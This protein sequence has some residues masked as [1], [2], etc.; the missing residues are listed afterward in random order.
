MN[1]TSG[2]SKMKVYPIL[3]NIILVYLATASM[4]LSCIHAQTIQNITLKDDLSPI[5]VQLSDINQSKNIFNNLVKNNP[6]RNINSI[7][8]KGSI[9][10]SKS[11]DTATINALA[12]AAVIAPTVLGCATIT[13]G[14]VYN[15]TTPSAGSYKCY[16]FIINSQSKIDSLA[17]LP[18]GINGS[19]YLYYVDPSTGQLTTLL[20][21]DKSPSSP[22]LV[23]SVNQ[24]VRLVFVVQP[25]NGTGGQTFQLGALNRLGFDSYE[26]NDKISTPK[27][28]S[29]NQTINANI[30]VA[31]IDKD[32]YFFPLIIGQSSTEVLATFNNSTQTA[33]IRLA[34]K[35]TN[36]T[37]T[38]G[39]ETPISSG[40]SYT[41]TGMPT[42]TPST[43]YG[44][45]LRITGTNT[46][47]INGQTYSARVGVGNAYMFNYNQYNTENI[48]RLN[49]FYGTS[50]LTT[51]NYITLETKVMGP[52]GLPVK[53]ELVQ[54]DVE[55]NELD[56]SNTHK[57][58]YVLTD[59]T[60]KAT[61]TN[62]FTPCLL[63]YTF[64]ETYY[65][66]GVP[67]QKWQGEL[68]I[69]RWQITLPRSKAVT[70]Q[71]TNII[72]FVRMCKE[73]YLGT[74]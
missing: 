72:R 59:A 67:H 54:F 7:A 43:P 9:P 30:D 17:A 25:S 22:L 70:G 58:N 42:Q 47:A 20:D 37:Y 71:Q 66:Y 21:N 73:T 46:T 10:V 1:T 51:A 56:P 55:S 36:G 12:A 38:Y 44:I 49:S 13:I 3:K 35:Q 34:Q 19:L 57:T 39:T 6:S 41:F 5:N 45:I 48:T 28:I 29:M 14:Y 8:K 33:G 4:W 53:D 64:T 31:G 40:T 2:F 69:G 11:S 24:N 15:D 74:F 68:Q 50:G 65:S 60:G 16:Q 63:P 52:D 18:V 32:Y 26:P 23:Q 27:T 62:N 61:W